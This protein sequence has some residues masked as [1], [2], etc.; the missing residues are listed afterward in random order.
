M[1]SAGPPP[2]CRPGVARQ[3]TGQLGADESAQVFDTT[4]ARVYGL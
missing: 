1:A 3:L 2:N 4:A